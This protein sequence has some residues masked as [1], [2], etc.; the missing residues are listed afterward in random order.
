MLAHSSKE[1][2]VT[3]HCKHISTYSKGEIVEQE[4]CSGKAVE[5]AVRSRKLGNNPS[6][7]TSYLCQSLQDIELLWTSTS[8]SEK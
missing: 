5:I 8:A 4:E 7:V 1:G 6:C 3:F 2:P